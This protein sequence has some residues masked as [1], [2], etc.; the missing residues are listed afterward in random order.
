MFVAIREDYDKPLCSFLHLLLL[1]LRS[2]ARPPTTTGNR[3]T[4]KPLCLG[5]RYIELA[6]AF[7]SISEGDTDSRPLTV[8][9][10]LTALI[11]DTDC[12][13]SQWTLPPGR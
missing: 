1:S 5:I 6:D 12:L 4:A 9:N 3:P 2:R 8:L 10:L 13:L 11:G 7:A